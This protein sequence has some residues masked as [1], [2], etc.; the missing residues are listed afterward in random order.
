MSNVFFRVAGDYKDETLFD[1]EGKLKQTE[2]YGQKYCTCVSPVDQFPHGSP[3]FN[4]EL[5]AAMEQ[6]RQTKTVFGVFAASCVTEVA[7][8]K[9]AALIQKREAVIQKEDDEPMA[10]PMGYEEPLTTNEV[11]ILQVEIVYYQL[12][13]VLSGSNF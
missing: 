4:C 9:R 8:R 2:Y 11:C 10:Y 6:C 7:R 12:I 13:S 5:T 3:E 1:P